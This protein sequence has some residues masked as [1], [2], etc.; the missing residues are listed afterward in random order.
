MSVSWATQA[1]GELWWVGEKHRWVFFDDVDTSET[2]AE[3]VGRCPA[4][5]QPLKRENLS[6]VINPAD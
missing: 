4:C 3:Q 6:M 2:Y 5:G 1:L